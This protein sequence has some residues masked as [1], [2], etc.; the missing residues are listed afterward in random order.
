MFDV[1]LS[2]KQVSY[3]VSPQTR[4]F[5]DRLQKVPGSSSCRSTQLRIEHALGAVR[6]DFH[7]DKVWGSDLANLFVDSEIAIR[8]QGKRYIVSLSEKIDLKLGIAHAD[9]DQFDLA[10]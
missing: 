5:Q 3:K 2:K 8:K 4:I 9:A 10:S 7:A 6:I 1:H